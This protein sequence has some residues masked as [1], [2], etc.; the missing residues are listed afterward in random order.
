MDP[1]D[2]YSPG[3]YKRLIKPRS[4]FCYWAVRE[5]GETATSLA[6]KLGL[7]QAGVSKSVLRGEKIV[8]EM[9]LKLF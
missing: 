2:I 3:K 9:D 5:L 4:V 6:I 7:T 8:K 1:G